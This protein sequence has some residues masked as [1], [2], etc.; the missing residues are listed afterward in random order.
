MS[1]RIEK[2]RNF[3]KNDVNSAIP[4]LVQEH[5]E[6]NGGFSDEDVENLIKEC[7]VKI[8]GAGENAFVCVFMSDPAVL[9]SVCCDDT[10]RFGEYSV[11]VVD[12]HSSRFEYKTKEFDAF[13]RYWNSDIVGYF[14]Q[15][16]KLPEMD[17]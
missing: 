7:R 9:V 13:V 11:E 5:T 6:L 3:F 4:A 2:L 14:G 17:I 16:A 12:Q 15:K 10:G 1:E 8:I